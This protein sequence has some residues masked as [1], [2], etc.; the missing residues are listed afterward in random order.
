MLDGNIPKPVNV[1]IEKIEEFVK[2]DDRQKLGLLDNLLENYQ[3]TDFVDDPYENEKSVQENKFQEEINNN[4][5][6][7][8]N[9]KTK[10]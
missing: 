6:Q 4:S 2:M 1:E 10:A 7:I 8:K 9:F 3:S 5:A